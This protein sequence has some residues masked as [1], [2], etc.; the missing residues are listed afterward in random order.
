MPGISMRHRPADELRMIEVREFLV[1][2]LSW[3][4]I[5]TPGNPTGYCG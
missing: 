3:D 4:E 2:I 1:D 5:Q